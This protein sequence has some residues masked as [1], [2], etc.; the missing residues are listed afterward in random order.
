MNR[1]YCKNPFLKKCSNKR[2]V[3]KYNVKCP[4]YYLYGSLLFIRYI[5]VLIN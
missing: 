4:P 2:G 1:F 3:E 5:Y